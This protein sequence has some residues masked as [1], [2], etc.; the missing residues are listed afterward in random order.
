VRA[1]LLRDSIN[2]QLF[3]LLF[4]CACS[5]EQAN[6]ASMQQKLRTQRNA[7]SHEAQ[8]GTNPDAE[9]FSMAGEMAKPPVLHRNVTA[10][11][12]L[13]GKAP[14]KKA[15][16]GKKARGGM[17]GAGLQSIVND[18]GPIAKAPALIPPGP[19]KTYIMVKPDGV[20]RGCVGEIIA[21]F[22]AKGFRLCALQLL[23]AGAPLLEVSS[24]F[25][26]CKCEYTKR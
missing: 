23:S 4:A 11:T 2:A 19:E 24:E 17:T 14:T 22:E 18:A 7:T 6:K 8:A 5:L 25:S 13:P 12:D 20:Q 16:K 3:F 10:V 15:A 26:R 9:L 1:L 21:R